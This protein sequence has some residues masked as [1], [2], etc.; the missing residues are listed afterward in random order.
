MSLP[1]AVSEHYRAQQRLVVATSALVSAAWARMDFEH[2]D[3][4]WAAVAPTIA[5]VVSSGQ[6]GAARNGA[7]Y[8]PAA[9]EEQGLP[10]RSLGSVAPRAFTGVASNGG[11]LMDL[12]SIAPAKVK[13][14]QSLDAGGAWL[15]LVAHTSVQDAARGAAGVSIAS[16]VGAGWVRMVNPPCC[17]RCAVLA[18][19][20]FRFNRGFQRHPRCDCTHIPT[21][22][23]N[24]NDVGIL[25]GPEDVKDLTVKQRRAI[26]D[27]ADINQVINSS[28]GRHKSGLTTSEGATRRGLAGKRLGAGRGSRARRLTPEGIYRQAGDDRAEAV[29]LLRAHGYII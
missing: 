18:G 13:Q 20:F 28:R 2:V 21:A 23:A 25:I 6:L 8:V 12:L 10:T 3:E 22:E 16:T 29:R 26:D 27:G 14:A 9:L 19:K 24:S 7:R 17:Q 1:T 5:T 11:S 4:S 15:D